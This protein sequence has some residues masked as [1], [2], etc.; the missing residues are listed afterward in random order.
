MKNSCEWKDVGEC[1]SVWPQQSRFIWCSFA[2]FAVLRGLKGRFEE[3]QWG[4]F[5]RYSQTALQCLMS[6]MGLLMENDSGV[7]TGFSCFSLIY[8]YF[9]LIRRAAWLSESPSPQKQGWMVQVCPCCTLPADVCNGVLRATGF[10]VALQMWS[11]ASSV[12][13]GELVSCFAR[14]SVE[15]PL[16]ET[17]EKYEWRLRSPNIRLHKRAFTSI[18]EC[19]VVQAICV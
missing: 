18:V 2:S 16:H 8:I 3:W 9:T 17:V 12:S 15:I 19:S 13:S 4:H 7:F 11:D 14:D 6:S 10:P 5:F 1:E